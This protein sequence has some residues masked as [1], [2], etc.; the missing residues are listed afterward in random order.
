MLAAGQRYLRDL[1]GLTEIRFIES[2]EEVPQDV[3]SAVIDG[4]E[5]FVPL[6]DLVDYEAERV[7]LGKEQ[8]R[9]E[10]EVARVN[11]KLGNPGFVSKAPEKLVQEEREKL[12]K[13]Q[14][15]L[16][17]VTAQLAAVER[18]LGR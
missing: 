15:M 7:R 17:K 16:E 6:A 14:E 13:Y 10:G 1:G 11:G 9:L 18:K 12:V 8:K 2:R 3:M 5:I 4:A